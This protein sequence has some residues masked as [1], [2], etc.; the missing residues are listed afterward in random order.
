MARAKPRGKKPPPQKLP[1]QV[2]T[3]TLTRADQDTLDQLST[4][5]TDYTGRSI[6][7]SAVVRALIRYAGRQ[8]S[9]WDL[10]ALSPLIEQEM[11]AGVL[12]G[13]KK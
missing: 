6:S 1:L 11:G 13:K 8:P 4:D 9:Q 7:G 12:W 2:R 10:T 5:L 3:I